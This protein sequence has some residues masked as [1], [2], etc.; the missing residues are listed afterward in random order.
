MV[1]V[2]LFRILIIIAIALLIYTAVQYFRKPERRLRRAREKES[3]YFLDDAENSKKNMQFVYKGCLFEG[4]KYLGTTERSFEVVNIHVSVS[5]PLDL[6]GM[7]R[8][9]LYFLEKEILI[10][11]PDA[12][13]EWKHPISE[14]LLTSIE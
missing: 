3:F 7:T 1:V 9:D 14:L 2:I 11:Y 4:V 8:D 6:R 12:K 10:R 13:I 5:D